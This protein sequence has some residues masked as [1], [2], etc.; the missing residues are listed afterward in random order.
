[1]QIYDAV[2]TL[3]AVRQYQEKAIPAETVLRIVQA[4]QLTG[5][6]M[7]RQPWRFIVVQNRDTLRQLGEL[8]RSGPYIA[9]AALAIVV[10]IE[11]TQFAVS[12]ASCAVQ[13]MMLTAWDEGVGS[14]WVGWLGMPEVNH[15]L[16]IP[17]HLDVL[18]ILPFGY[19][20]Q[21]TGQ[22]KKRRKALGEVAYNE[23]FG[24]PFD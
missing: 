13:S 2:R 4:G 21:A 24:E 5:S 12:D 18:A 14:N 11:R 17:H 22:G 8:A 23:H 9:Q 3:L 16:G 15:L 1:M 19:P 7:N 6:S 10:V 20:A